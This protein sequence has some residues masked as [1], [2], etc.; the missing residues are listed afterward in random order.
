MCKLMFFI[1]VLALSAIT[2]CGVD[3]ESDEGASDLG[4]FAA[5]KSDF[6]HKFEAGSGYGGGSPNL[7]S[8]K[9]VHDGPG[10]GPDINRND[11]YSNP[12][13]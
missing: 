12:I 4:Q 2:A 1:A 13:R 10:C 6:A 8:L 11:P 9:C 3:V 5:A 7:Q